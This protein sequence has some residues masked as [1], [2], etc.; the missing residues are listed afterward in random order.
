MGISPFARWKN[1]G[2]GC[3]S[4]PTVIDRFVDWLKRPT[5]K[6]VVGNPDPLKFHITLTHQAG[7]FIAVCIVYPDAKNYEG[8]KVMV[9]RATREELG[10]LEFLDPHFCEGNHLSPIARFEPTERGWKYAVAFADALSQER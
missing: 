1:S 9:L 5:E 3:E 4:E 10:K 6:V 8:R 2:C 7:P